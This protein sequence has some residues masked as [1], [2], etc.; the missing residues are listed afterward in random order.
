[1]FAPAGDAEHRP[2]G[3][4]AGP[5]VGTV[6]PGPNGGRRRQDGTAGLA[7]SAP[8]GLA[9][10]EHIVIAVQENRSFDH[11]FGTFPGDNGI[12]RRGGEFTVCLPDPKLS[13][14]AK[15]FHDDNM[16]ESGGGPRPGR[17]DHRR[18]R[19]QDERVRAPGPRQGQLLHQVL[20]FDAYLKLI[21]DR[22]LGGRRIR[23]HIGRPDAR[24]TGERM[25]I[26]GDLEKEFDFTQSPIP[27][28]LL[29]L[30]PAPGA[31]SILDR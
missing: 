29:P 24:P 6:R 30:D 15:P 13:R 18:E 26:L 23:R 16:Y 7:P 8:A 1:M 22:F 27:P 2:K 31:A 11:Y 12:P 10:I 20:S 3:P 5:K 21:E 25:P 4:S 28:M 9:K 17:V 19:R 14:C